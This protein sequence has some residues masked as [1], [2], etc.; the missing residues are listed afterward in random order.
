MIFIPGYVENIINLL[1]QTGSKAYVVGGCVRDGIIGRNTADFD[2]TCDATPDEVIKILSGVRVIETGIKHGTVTAITKDGNIEITT[3][4][5]DGAYTD[6]RHPDGVC[7]TKDIREDLSRRDFTMNALAYNHNDGLIDIFDGVKDIQNHTVRCVGD[8]RRRF[9]EDALRILRAVRFAAVLG[10][11]LEEKT[12]QAAKD[13]CGLLT[14]ISRERIFEEVKK[15]VCGDFADVVIKKYRCIIFS[16]L[17]IKDNGEVFG[18]LANA[19]DKADIR[20]ALLLKNFP[21]VQKI[22]AS[23]KC[24]RA[25]SE[26]VISLV[27]DIGFSPEKEEDVILYISR[28]GEEHADKLALLKGDCIFSALLKK[29]KEKRCCLNIKD[30]DIKGDDIIKNTRLRN[31]EIGQA[32]EELFALVAK[33]TLENKN[34]VLLGYLKS[35][36]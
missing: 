22:M 3:H 6:N 8:P 5:T 36:T 13:M 33:G 4:R 2:V 19:P 35:K 29:V 9:E 34:E 16:A 28:Y 18:K 32:L 24:S 17:G 1:T 27:R 12:S 14:N 15:L 30:L 20:F 31:E 10:F 26:S 7:F 21:D 11:E 25:F 23:L